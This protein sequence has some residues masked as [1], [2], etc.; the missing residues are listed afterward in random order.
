MRQPARSARRSSS[1]GGLP[2]S[3]R[4]TPDQAKIFATTITN[5]SVIVMDAKSHG[6]LTQFDLN[7][8]TERYRFNGGAPDPTG[9]FFYTTLLRMDK[10]ID[11]WKV[12]K[13]MY[14][15]ID[16]KLKKVVRTADLEP[17]DDALSGGY[18]APMMVSPDGKSLY[19][20]KDK[21]L[22]VDTAKLKVVD[23]ID[24]QKPESTGYANVAFGGGVE[25]FQ[26]TTG[27]ELVSL[28]TA[29]DPFVHNKVFG[30]GRFDL[31]TRKFRFT[32][33]GP[34]T[35]GMSGLEITPDGKTGYTVVTN[36]QT[37]NKRCEFWKFDM[38]SLKLKDKVEFGLP[39][40][41]PAWHVG[42]RHQALYLRRELR[43]RGLRRA[44]HEAGKDLGSRR[45]R[46]HGR[47]A[48]PR[49]EA[50]PSTAARQSSVPMAAPVHVA[51]RGAGIAAA[52]AVLA[53]NGIAFSTGQGPERGAAPVVMLGEQALH[54]LDGLF[55]AGH[56][57]GSHRI[58]RRI[59][60][61]N[62]AEAVAIPHRAVAISGQDLLRALPSTQSAPRPAPPL[63]TLHARPPEPALRSFGHRE[64][65]AAPVTLAATADPSAVLVEAVGAGWLFLIPLGA[66]G[67]WLLAVGD[68]P[69]AL[70]AEQPAGLRPPSLR[71]GRSKPASRQRRACWSN[72]WAATGWP[73]ATPRSR[74][75]RCAAMAPPRRR[76]AA[77][78]P[79]A[80][81][82]A[83]TEGAAPAPLLRHYRRH[84]HCRAASP[85]RRLPAVLP[86]RRHRRLVAGAGQR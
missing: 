85:P 23:R 61:W 58:T 17:E 77:F 18:R 73:W 60:L 43:Y 9:R 54:L 35:T 14:A 12:S 63:F 53:E 24:V 69:N 65:A 68:T 45:R 80:V 7:T 46:N 51:G 75:I 84:A 30:L 39:L 19:L 83:I 71:W 49:S 70:L 74:S 27:S 31:N 11:R 1:P 2:V 20:F 64:A 82:S 50:V 21:V 59:V 22:V 32:P 67:G 38:A 47:N 42:R 13:Q 36:G 86:A 16:I 4:I 76:A 56:V 48:G 72:W 10:L 66:Q 44:D 29:A 34:I 8:P 62:E 33:M 79:A 37:G 40:A 41:L 15:V 52:Q 81:A 57:A 25:S 3:L 28:F 5:S 26:M 78:W 55:G 6:I